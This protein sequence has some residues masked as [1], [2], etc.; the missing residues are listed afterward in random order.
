MNKKGA[1]LIS[2]LIVILSIVS[3]GINSRFALERSA[4]ISRGEVATVVYNETLKKPINLIGEWTFYSDQLLTPE[5]VDGAEGGLIHVPSD[6]KGLNAGPGTYRLVIPVD[7]PGVYGLYIHKIRMHYNIYING[8]HAVTHGTVSQY[9]EDFEAYEKPAFVHAY[10]DSGTFDVVIQVINYYTE[11]GG[12]LSI[13]E[14]GAYEG[15]FKTL[16]LRLT[17]DLMMFSIFFT[18]G[19]FMVILY[20]FNRKKQHHL[21]FGIY[22]IS[23][24]V[25]LTTH[26]QQVFQLIFSKLTINTMA[27][28]QFLLIFSMTLTLMFFQKKFL[29]GCY[30]ENVFKG[31]VILQFV[32]IAALSIP[33][34]SATAARYLLLPIQITVIGA[35]FTAFFYIFLATYDAM[36]NHVR[37]A[38][39]LFILSVSHTTYGVLLALY[40]FFHMQLHYISVVIQ[41]ISVSIVVV[42]MSF[43]SSVVEREHEMY[44]DYLT[45]FNKLK[46]DTVKKIAHMIQGPIYN[47]FQLTNL[48]EDLDKTKQHDLIMAFHKEITPLINMMDQLIAITNEEFSGKENRETIFNLSKLQLFLEEISVFYPPKEGVLLIYDEIERYVSVCFDENALFQ[49]LFNVIQNAIK[50]TFTGQIVIMVT[51]QDQEAIIE[52]SDTGLGLDVQKNIEDELQSLNMF[53]RASFAMGN[54]ELGLNYAKMIIEQSNGSFEIKTKKD[55]GTK[56]RMHIPLSPNN[57]IGNESEA[58]AHFIHKGSNAYSIALLTEDASVQN[59]M[60]KTLS[61]EG[62]SLYVTHEA[63]I[64]MQWINSGQI[65][66][67]FV[68]SVL[69]HQSTVPFCK[70]VRNLFNHV[71][72]PLILISYLAQSVDLQKG[73]NHLYNDFLNKPIH[74][75]AII[76]RID[77]LLAIKSAAT[78]AYKRE[79]VNLQNQIAPHFLFN[80]L[81]TIIGLS[82][83][84]EVKTREALEYLAIYFRGK[85][86]YASYTDLIPLKEEIQLVKAY[87]A[88][89]SIR[90][91]SK[92]EISVYEDAHLDC[93]IPAMTIQPLVEN[94]ICHGILKSDRPGILKLHAQVLSDG[95]YLVKIV[96]NGVGMDAEEVENLLSNNSVGIGFSNVSKKLNLISGASI[97]VNS[98][99]NVG[100]EIKV[101]FA[102]GALDESHTHR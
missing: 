59:A 81:N 3:I 93:M 55:I 12:I 57:S 48:Q 20:V 84:D 86:S 70:K 67:V 66:L 98:T 68:D 97:E 43:H 11:S 39:L 82:Y 100:T 49:S 73:F 32:G 83:V 54:T 45:D 13:P 1:V 99:P 44:L 79:I 56:V 53:V 52:V 64:A 101:Y 2:M 71:E 46:N 95:R 22:N 17:I 38:E 65:D 102:G 19:L 30:K 6:W 76:S 16:N 75:K 34:K 58:Y 40:V 15:V 35:A 8:E 23:F 9:I 33:I 28:I 89:E 10:V 87:M 5:Q 14:F 92:L 7:Q 18:M 50:Y 47:M 80:T 90:F 29:N 77:V 51:T 62:Y 85:L 69:K 41:L 26:G 63:S 94:A 78:N 31:V 72:L 36:K 21:Y 27:N 88:I 42:L 37:G 60:I 74:P 96:D 91:E 25:F 61:A 24:A 4:D